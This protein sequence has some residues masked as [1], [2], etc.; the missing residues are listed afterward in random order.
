MAKAKKPAST[1]GEAKDT[2]K[3]GQEKP[4]GSVPKTT[5]SRTSAPKPAAAAKAKPDSTVSKDA[6]APKPSTPTPTPTPEAVK[7]A[8]AVRT[9]E[10]T[11]TP[12]VEKTE[13]A[14]PEKPKT[15]VSSD[16]TIQR[17]RPPE[18]EKSGSIFWPLLIGGALAAVMGFVA[19]EMNVLGTR[20]DTSDLRAAISKQQIQI[21]ELANAE[22]KTPNIEFPAL[23][24]L[25][26]DLAELSK[27]VTAIDVRLTEVEKRPISEGSSSTA[28]VAAYER[29]LQALQA[30][31]E[32]QLSEIEGLLDNALSVEEATA[33]ASRKATLQ[34]A[35]TRITAA[36]NGGKPFA[37]A[38]S[39]LEANGMGDT[40]QA[41][42]GV[43]DSGVVTLINL[44]SRFPNVA[45]AAL[46]SA[47]AVGS[48]DVEGGVGGF[49]RR[50]LGARSVA[51]REGT[52]PDAVLSRVEA[53]VR[54]GRLT[55]A[56]AEIDTL[57]EPSQNA[58]Q[59][60]IVDARARQAAE[61]AAED[62]SQRLTAN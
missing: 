7:A 2:P 22:P 55:D 5:R 9:A 4:A 53:A 46:S 61:A 62:L 47:R 24:A 52:D 6:G 54:D 29:E 13:K 18:P 44:Q 20:S 57:P 40:P 48:D 25:T 14:A 38:L 50:Q 42:A 3:A 1:G 32:K 59:D 39:E 58:M 28:A 60:W 33:E 23:D 51:P 36:I 26:A 15:T 34:G 41:L 8:E 19:S 11:K 16:S 45:R 30:S 31:V 49:L 56:L 10:A 37:S 12:E 27:T 43:A 21:T 35:L 17:P